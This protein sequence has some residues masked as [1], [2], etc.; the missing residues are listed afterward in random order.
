MTIRHSL[1]NLII[2]NDPRLLDIKTLHRLDRASKPA[3]IHYSQLRHALSGCLSATV[4]EK[5][6]NK[7]E[8]GLLLEAMWQEQFAVLLTFDRMR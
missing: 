6:D 5:F 8:I 4:Q 7:V 1:R 2:Q 3:E